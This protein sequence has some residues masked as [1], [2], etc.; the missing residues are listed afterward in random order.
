MHRW[1]QEETLPRWLHIAF[2]TIN[3]WQHL[4]FVFVCNYGGQMRLL[5]LHFT[6]GERGD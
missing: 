3:Q 5:G 1:Q 6:G 4:A 2:L